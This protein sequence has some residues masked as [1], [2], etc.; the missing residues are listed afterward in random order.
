MAQINMNGKQSFLLNDIKQH[1]A[2]GGNVTHIL[3]V[4]VSNQPEN[5]GGSR[6]RQLIFNRINNIPITI[7]VDG[8]DVTVTWRSNAVSSSAYYHSNNIFIDTI[9]KKHTKLLLRTVLGVIDNAVGGVF[10]NGT[11]GLAFIVTKPLV[12]EV[13]LV[14]DDAD[15]IFQQ[16]E[17]ELDVNEEQL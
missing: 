14:D 7:N 1:I 4:K 13:V 3:N 16:D 15:I 2:K 5:K 6:I 8:T 9:V 17:D 11:T 12:R 10:A